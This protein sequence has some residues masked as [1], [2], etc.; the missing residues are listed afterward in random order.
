MLKA[1]GTHRHWRH[2]GGSFSSVVSL[3][4]VYYEYT[5]TVQLGFDAENA[6]KHRWSKHLSPDFRL[7]K[8]K[9]K[10]SNPFARS[11]LL[12]AFRP[13]SSELAAG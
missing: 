11:F 10:R 1:V 2:S 7:P 12:P 9:V 8:L 6:C 13:W 3:L 4:C 5:V